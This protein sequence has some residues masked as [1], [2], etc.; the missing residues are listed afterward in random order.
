MKQTAYAL[1]LVALM[2]VFA[3]PPLFAADATPSPAAGHDA[4]EVIATRLGLRT[5]AGGP[6]A[7]KSDVVLLS[8]DFGWQQPSLVSQAYAGPA[9]GVPA[10]AEPGEETVPLTTGAWLMGLGLVAF[11]ISRKRFKS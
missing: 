6:P 5:L 1:A 3:A 9:D 2:L 11:V 4:P 8:G 7:D 10:P